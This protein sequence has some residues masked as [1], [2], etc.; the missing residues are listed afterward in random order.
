MSKI[1]RTCLDELER[2]YTNRLHGSRDTSRR[3]RHHGVGAL[4]RHAC[5]RETI[6]RGTWHGS[7]NTGQGGE[8][9]R[10]GGNENVR[11]QRSA[12]HV[13][14][15]TPDRSTCLPQRRRERHSKATAITRALSSNGQHN[16]RRHG[17]IVLWG[18]PSK[19]TPQENRCGVRKVEPDDLQRRKPISIFSFS[20]SEK[21][22]VSTAL[23]CLLLVSHLLMS[24]AHDRAACCAYRGV[25][26]RQWASCSCEV[27]RKNDAA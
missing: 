8:K 2:P 21:P 5:W 16:S 13:K 11:I 14:I 9:K 15:I 1:T 6:T 20:L 24:Y 26:A 18:M 17:D 10:C 25:K 22:R 4:L 19:A 7:N 12:K 3:Q 23:P 27:R